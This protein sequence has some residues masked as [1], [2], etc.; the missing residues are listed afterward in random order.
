MLED[1]EYIMRGLIN[2]ENGA[3]DLYVS[4]PAALWHLDKLIFV[5]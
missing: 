5:P 4:P 2:W 1:Q 3:D